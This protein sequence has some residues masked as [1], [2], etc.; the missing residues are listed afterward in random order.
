ML[1]CIHQGLSHAEGVSEVQSNLI[2]HR[3]VPVEPGDLGPGVGRQH[4]QRLDQQTPAERGTGDL[5]ATIVTR[6]ACRAVGDDEPVT[7]NARRRSSL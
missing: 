1:P 4:G 3:T 5:H 7:R 2:R 6:Y